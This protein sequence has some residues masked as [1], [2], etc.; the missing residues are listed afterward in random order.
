LDHEQHE[1]SEHRE[2]ANANTYQTIPRLTGDIAS[3][4]T[5]ETSSCSRNFGS[6]SQNFVNKKKQYHAA[7]GEICR[8]PGE[9]PGLMNH[10]VTR[11]NDTSYA[12]TDSKGHF[13]SGRVEDLFLFHK[14]VALRA[15]FL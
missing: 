3:G 10:R 2:T 5:E 15:T 1:I 6:K 9:T 8:S 13:A 7:A 4:R 12:V 11:V 14:N